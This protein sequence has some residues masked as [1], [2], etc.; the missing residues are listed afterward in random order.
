MKLL[1][2]LCLFFIFSFSAFTKADG[3]YQ[4]Y[5]EVDDSYYLEEMGDFIL[6]HSDVS[7]PIFTASDYYKIYWNGQ[8][9]QTKSLTRAEWTSLGVS[10]LPKETD[11]IL[12]GDFN[13]DQR[14]DLIIRGDTF[15]SDTLLFENKLSGKKVSVVNGHAHG[16]DLSIGNLQ[17]KVS[18]R[19]GDGIDD[20][21]DG[22]QIM[23]GSANGTMS[24][25]GDS[26]PPTKPIISQGNQVGE[27]AFN[28]TVIPDGSLKINVPVALP[29]APASFLPH[30][31]FAYNSAYSPKG[32]GIM[33]YGW[34]LNATKVIH[35]CS[36]NLASDGVANVSPIQFNES[37]RLCLNG[38]RLMVNSGQLNKTVSDAEYWRAGQ[39]YH[40]EIDSLSTIT[41]GPYNHSYKTISNFSM[42][43]KSGVTYEFAH[44]EVASGLKE[45]GGD[46][47]V[48]GWKLTRSVDKFNNVIQYYYDDSDIAEQTLSAIEFLGSNGRD[49]SAKVEFNYIAAP[50]KRR[51]YR[52]NS[53]TQAKN[54]KLLDNVSVYLDQQLYRS[55]NLN[56]D[57]KEHNGISALLSSIQECAIS[58]TNC[59]KPVEF[60]WLK[61]DKLSS[62]QFISSKL[63]LHLRGVDSSS[64]KIADI[65]G[66]G[67][68]DL[69]YFE[70]QHLKFRSGITG[71]VQGFG[72][73]QRSNFK[74]F[75]FDSDGIDDLVFARDA[76]TYI[77]SWQNGRVVEI[78]TGVSFGDG[79]ADMDGDGLIDIVRFGDRTKNYA[80][81][82]NQPGKTKSLQASTIP[83]TLGMQGFQ[84]QCANPNRYITGLVGDINGDGKAEF[85]V[86]H[87]CKGYQQAN[88]YFEQEELQ[89]SGKLNYTSEKYSAADSEFSNLDINGDGLGDF[90]KIDTSSTNARQFYSISQGKLNLITRISSLQGAQF[91][92]DLNGDGISDVF[93]LA[94]SI[95]AIY[96]TRPIFS[97]PNL[98]APHC[99]SSINESS[100]NSGFSA[101]LYQQRGGICFYKNTTHNIDV[102]RCATDYIPSKDASKKIIGCSS[103][104]ESLK[105][106][107]VFETSAS[108]I[109]RRFLGV[110][111]KDGDGKK[112]IILEQN[113]ELFAYELEVPVV[114]NRISQVTSLNKTTK[115]TYATNSDLSIYPNYH[116]EL[117]SLPYPERRVRD[118]I[119]V[120]QID[121]PAPDSSR[122]AINYQYFG[123]KTHQQGR[124]FLGFAKIITT[125]T[126]SG[127]KTE[128]HYSQAFPYIGMVTSKTVSH[129]TGT[130][131]T[132]SGVPH[133]ITSAQGG[134][135]PY[136]K[137]TTTKKYD[138]ASNG[139]NPL[140][141]ETSTASQL[142]A[143]GNAT[144][145]TTTT[146]GDG[147]SYSTTVATAYNGSYYSSAR[148]GRPSSQSKTYSRTG[149]ANKTSAVTY[150]YHSNGALKD[151]I[152]Q[153]GDVNQLTTSY[154]YDSYGNINKKS[155]TGR[156]NSAG[157]SQ[158]RSETY[159][160]ANHGRLLASYTNALG[161]TESYEY[162]NASAEN[163]IGP[164]TQQ[165]HF[166]KN[167]FASETQYDYFGRAIQVIGSDHVLTTI[168]RDFC[169]ADC[170]DVNQAYSKVT[171][172]TQGQPVQ[173][174]YFDR[175]SNPVGESSIG[176]DGQAVVSQQKYDWQG[177]VYVVSQPGK[178]RAS[179]IESITRYDV[180][181]RARSKTLK[182]RDGDRTTSWAYLG[183]TL[184]VTEPNGAQHSKT[185]NAL[186]EPIV[187]ADVNQ[188]AINFYYYANGQLRLTR[189]GGDAKT[190]ISYHYD[191]FGNKTAVKSPGKGAESYTY[192]AF[193]DMLSSKNARNQT[194]LY[195]YDILGRQTW[196]RE[197]EG[198]NCWRYDSAQYGKGQL[199]QTFYV[200]NGLDCNNDVQAN[201]NKRYHYNSRGLQ[202]A[203]TTKI[204]SASYKITQ[205][206]DQYARIEQLDLPATTQ[207]A[208]KFS[209]G[210]DY[211]SEGH[212]SQIRQITGTPKVLKQ[213]LATD[214]FGNVTQQQLGNGVTLNKNYRQDTGEA[215]SIN[216]ANRLATSY[217]YNTSGNMASR[218]MRFGYGSNVRQY[219]QSFGYDTINRLKTVT[220]TASNQL[221]HSYQY[222]N[223]GNITPTTVGQD[224][225]SYD[226][227]PNDPYK[228]RS[229]NGEA[230]NYDASGNIKN[231]NGY[232][233]SYTSFDKV[234]RISNPSNSNDWTEYSYGTDGE[235]FKKVE[236]RIYQGKVERLT[237]EF[238]HAFY[239]RHSRHGGA[240]DLVEEKYFIGDMVLTQRSNNTK[241]SYY[242]IK[243][244]QGSVLMTLN[245]SGQ[246]VNRYYYRPF[247]EQIDVSLNPLG[248][249]T[250]RPTQ[251][252]YT[253]HEHIK[254]LDIINMGGRIYAAGL[255]RFLQADP[256]VGHPMYS[257]SYNPYQY[258]YGNPMVNVDPS[259]YMVVLNQAANVGV[260]ALQHGDPSGQA[261]RNLQIAGALETAIAQSS[262]HN[263]LQLTGDPVVA[264]M[265]A[266]AEK[267]G[268]VSFPGKQL[269]GEKLPN[270]TETPISD[271][272]GVTST[273]TQP[274]DYNGSI[275]TA[276]DGQEVVESNS[277]V[278]DG[279]LD[280]VEIGLNVVMSTSELKYAPTD[281]HRKGGWG[282]EMDLSDE[283]AQSVL[284]NS[285]QGGKQR[286]NYHEGRVYE[287]QPDN[288]EG[289]HGYPVKG[290]KVPPSII[291]Q[292]KERGDITKPQ[293][294]KLIK[295]KEISKN[296]GK[297]KD[298]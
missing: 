31:S 288:Q 67:T 292:L 116:T 253:G 189:I 4:L 71:A 202:S 80:I 24:F 95:A 245:G 132:F 86:K 139:S 148:H 130:I 142:D 275:N 70:D 243:D 143:W 254:D 124:G 266:A 162:N 109:V 236:N 2:A 149:E 186:G 264:A 154:G 146:S 64:I 44:A 13:G 76:K 201:I 42:V 77:L 180:L 140:V 238:I 83:Q 234:K 78:N 171:T 281:K 128:T 210:Y 157:A 168:S 160:Y 90:S 118:A 3:L 46:T 206:Y 88:Q 7:V 173:T 72:R 133:S 110:A 291:K 123:A 137:N 230:L 226:Y 144:S 194:V 273:E 26:V 217:T 48:Q 215:S 198:I 196:S 33:S 119:F 92:E 169:A 159:V 187:S 115:V 5:R 178:G 218:S 131:S 277:Y 14:K 30:V 207:T 216:V 37:D 47:I 188:L 141:S 108:A 250:L 228:L 6:I 61:K 167:G 279:G 227:D 19:N 181:S 54:T 87:S 229:H 91:I 32:L 161:Q 209:V 138:L 276:N 166:D 163:S 287:F 39:E 257:Q 55:Y 174:K 85:V 15:Y 103:P 211:N 221:I 34:T 84:G 73:A 121:Y 156:V 222:D 104:T 9:W 248:L 247:G 66:D 258:V 240:G 53:L 125:N 43:D 289:W 235:R 97:Q 179:S 182:A 175:F 280:G 190:D 22:L 16:M 223:L 147:N 294:N 38:Q 135:I 75:D 246:E 79:Y 283:V 96:L 164:I 224:S 51:H 249:Q 98:P 197:A 208:D 93:T 151:E 204:G 134:V 25:K 122:Y 145:Q 278:N 10:S 170:A 152:A 11:R 260:L 49:F 158:T 17:L 293:Y 184:T 136:L 112:E 114:N 101:F 150:R 28:L 183:R 203:V 52:A 185:T 21:V 126:R 74:V 263:A 269:V 297:E 219:Q 81:Y 60:G 127:I 27:T 65:D 295:G 45:N 57:Y 255:R 94:N 50:D 237:T 239:E 284:D 298:K 105:Y 106:E 69:M 290:T 58:K 113:H 36:K 89:Y 29:N 192:N 251:Y 191:V 111:D 256:V 155:Q 117:P 99:L 232:Q 177:R 18:D 23:Q 107:K 62:N 63:G 261:K 274:S 102:T 272:V 56:Y 153:P 172:S 212:L 165:V 200:P 259:G 268:L 252:G 20:L 59:L 286:Y 244:H 176:F 82:Y 271:A 285:F 205:H 231:Y 100:G 41:A 68:S 225:P 120:K 129:P 220:D 195:G 35:R 265:L 40:T 193:A 267:M 282:T 242:T 1:Y 270:R 8:S 241:D 12:F 213:I 199:A 296:N 262:Y 233:F 214:A